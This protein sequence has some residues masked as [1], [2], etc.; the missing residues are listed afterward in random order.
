MIL[1]HWFLC[2]CRLELN[3]ISRLTLLLKIL[4]YNVKP[5]AENVLDLWVF[6]QCFCFFFISKIFILLKF[7]W[8]WRYSGLTN[9]RQYLSMK[10]GRRGIGTF[11]ERIYLPYKIRCNIKSYFCYIFCRCFRKPRQARWKFLPR[12]VAYITLTLFKVCT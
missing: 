5:P 10:P 4:K 1:L 9:I 11:I 6:C 3:Q 8:Y 2:S 7:L 12:L